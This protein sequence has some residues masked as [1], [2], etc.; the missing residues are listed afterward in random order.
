MTKA[1][2]LLRQILRKYGS[3]RP[4]FFSVFEIK[5]LER[6]KKLNTVY[7]ILDEVVLRTEPERKLTP[8][9]EHWVEI[10]KQVGPASVKNL[11]CQS[12]LCEWPT[13]S[14]KY[15]ERFCKVLFIAIPGEKRYF[16]N[17]RSFGDKIADPEKQEWG[18]V[19]D[20]IVILG[21]THAG[22]VLTIGND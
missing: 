6:E 10:E 18:I 9:T 17:G 19:D 16:R 7:E 4:T 1:E 13:F 21:H 20:G 22:F 3:Y 12:I 2:R 14:E 5:E 8:S 11:L 15:A